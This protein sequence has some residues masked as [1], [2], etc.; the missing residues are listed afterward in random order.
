VKDEERRTSV[1]P[2]RRS[3][4]FL[5]LSLDGPPVVSHHKR[6]VGQILSNVTRVYQ[7]DVPGSCLFVVLEG[8]LSGVDGPG[9]S[10]VREN[11]SLTEN[12]TVRE[13][14]AAGVGD[15]VR[16]TYNG[17]GATYNQE[18]GNDRLIHQRSDPSRR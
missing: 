2:L 12:D 15:A 7:P 18:R 16:L 17:E 13:G 11:H 9:S 6:E 5:N 3:P 14:G 1:K 4:A 10:R 8:W